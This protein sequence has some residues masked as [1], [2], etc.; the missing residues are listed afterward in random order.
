MPSGRKLVRKQ[1]QQIESA[2]MPREPEATVKASK[3]RNDDAARRG[4]VRPPLARS[5][6]MAAVKRSNT[7]PELG[8]RRAL[9]AA[10]HRFRKDFPIRIDGRLLRP[11]IVFTKR[12]VAI[13]VDGCFWH[14]CPIHG[15]TPASNVEF[16][17]QKLC[18]NVERDRMQDRLLDKEGWTVLRIW[19]HTRVE[20]ALAEV[21]AVLSGPSQ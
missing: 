12:R 5:Q 19:E 16:W 3:R 1:F 13:F 17:T 7:R 10:G 4:Y 20:D 18:G 21:V 11:D 8:L 15:E 2:N 6:N 14:G 9:H